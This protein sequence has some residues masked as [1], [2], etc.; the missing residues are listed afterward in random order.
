MSMSQPHT[1][2]ERT[3]DIPLIIHW[4]LQLKLPEVLDDALPL[5]HGN[6]QGLIMAN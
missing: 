4:L 6:R 1:T 3:D 2:V 5:A